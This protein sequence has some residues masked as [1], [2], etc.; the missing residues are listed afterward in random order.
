MDFLIIATRK[1]GTSENEI[2]Y[3]KYYT[4]MN[5]SPVVSTKQALW[6]LVRANYKSHNYYS[7]NQRLGTRV[8]CEWRQIGNGDPFLQSDPNGTQKDNLLELP[9][10]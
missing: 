6:E 5:N 1:E 4:N 2:S 10:C 7:N 8:N 3:Y 9:D